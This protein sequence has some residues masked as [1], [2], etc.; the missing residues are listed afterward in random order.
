VTS[1]SQQSTMTLVPHRS[2]F[3]SAA[4]PTKIAAKATWRDVEKGLI[5]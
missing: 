1:Q 5:Q 2:D 4:K 3:P